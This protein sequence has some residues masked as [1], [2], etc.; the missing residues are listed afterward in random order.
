MTTP[1]PPS[2]ITMAFLASAIDEIMSL[3]P[4]PYF[5][6]SQVLYEVPAALQDLAEDIM[7]KAKQL[8]S[9]QGGA[10]GW[11]GEGADA[12][13]KVVT[14]L[15]DFFGLLAETV[16]GKAEPTNDAGEDILELQRTFMSILE[17]NS[18]GG[19]GGGP[20]DRTPEAFPSGPP[21]PEAFP[22]KPP[23]PE[24]VMT[25]EMYIA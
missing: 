20:T 21:A 13:M 1:L 18:A 17:A 15:V 9:E 6:A 4:N 24:P 2:P 7:Q 25:P 8:T 23:E 14:E 5:E 10:Q 11:T 16:K 19:A 12:F 3:D 22:S